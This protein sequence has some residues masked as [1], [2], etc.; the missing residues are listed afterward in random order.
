M[1]HNGWPKQRFII[2]FTVMTKYSELKHKL[3]SEWKI[4]YVD[5]LYLKKEI[6]A[7][8]QSL[9]YGKITKQDAERNFTNLVE[10]EL[11][12]V[13][14]FYLMG[15]NEIKEKLASLRK[16]LNQVNISI[17]C[18]ILFLFKLYFFL[19]DYEIFIF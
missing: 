4:Y 18:K 13:N 2:N 16:L 11:R 3:K 9:Q 14:E 6:A 17:Y 1:A 10:L 15:N 8:K 5:V 7:I 19:E 12:K